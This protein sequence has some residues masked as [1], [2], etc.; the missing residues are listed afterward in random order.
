MIPLREID[1]LGVFV[2]FA[3]RDMITEPQAVAIV[4]LPGDQMTWAP[5]VNLA[6][7]ESRELS[8]LIGARVRDWVARSGYDRILGMN[9]YHDDDAF[10]Q[11]FEH[12]GEPRVVG[13]IVEVAI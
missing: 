11:V 3:H 1:L 10:C 7:S 5:V 6:Y 13:S 9:L 2:G 4:R 12:V 8:V